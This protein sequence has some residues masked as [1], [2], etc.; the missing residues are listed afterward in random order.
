MYDNAKAH[1]AM[2][3]AITILNIEEGLSKEHQEKF[4][5]DDEYYDDDFTEDGSDDL[6]KVTFQI[7]V[8]RIEIWAFF[9]LIEL[10]SSP[11]ANPHFGA[12]PCTESSSSLLIL[13]G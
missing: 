1:A 3:H 4:R 9:F 11:G 7:E 8:F 13:V 12:E 5:C 2:Q 10:P 6:I